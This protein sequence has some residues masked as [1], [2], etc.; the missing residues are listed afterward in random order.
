MKVMLFLFAALLLILPVQAQNEPQPIRVGSKL[1]TEDVLLGHLVYVALEEAGYPVVDKLSTG[2]TRVSRD[3]LV[4]NEIDIYPEYTG[5]A[6]TLFFDSALIG[7]ITSY[8]SETVYGIVSSFDSAYND[9]VWLEPSPI[10]N[11]YV[12]VI[13]K[14]FSEANGILTLADFARYVNE[15][16]TVMFA[17]GEEFITRP[18]GMQ[19]LETAY[20]FDVRGSQM[21]VITDATPNMLVQALETGVN[22]INVA[23]ATGVSSLI[24]EYDLVALYDTEELVLPYEPV[25][26]IRGS[27]LRRNPEIVTILNPIFRSLDADT[28][29]RLVAQ[30]E[31]DGKTPRQVAIDYLA[32]RRAA[33]EAKSTD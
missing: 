31:I 30:V 23:L 1:F 28:L 25:P 17:A 20:G 27:L 15:G 26:V 11:S 12:M 29:I 6:L 5:T 10:D 32:E 22:G 8:D 9:L 16:G 3:A 24:Y 13:K 18:D 7:E 2:N 19:T 21:L 14:D 33:A 4:N